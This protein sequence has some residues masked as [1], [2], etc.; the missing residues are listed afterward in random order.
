LYWGR[1][2][3]KKK[4]KVGR[5]VRDTTVLGG[6]IETEFGSLKVPRQCPLVLLVKARLIFGR[7]RDKRKF[8]AVRDTTVLKHNLAV[9][10][11]RRQCLLVL[12]VKA[13]LVFGICSILIVKML[14]RL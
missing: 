6:V 8:G 14:E 9:W 2:R 5:L 1:E 7:E 3:E 12:L 10:K 11:V 4:K 13:R